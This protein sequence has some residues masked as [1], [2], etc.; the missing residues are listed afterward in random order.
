VGILQLKIL[1]LCSFGKTNSPILIFNRT[2]MA[3]RQ[4]VKLLASLM[5]NR[6]MRV[7]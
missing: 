2:V 7:R 5:V 6:D 3:S 1:E 4:Q